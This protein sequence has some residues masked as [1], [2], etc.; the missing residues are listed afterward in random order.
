MRINFSRISRGSSS[1]FCSW[2]CKRSSTDL[3]GLS[4]LRFA[5]LASLSLGLVWSGRMPAV[6]S[7]MPMSGRVAVEI[8]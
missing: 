1:R 8:W 5:L 3:E 7:V 2:A 4:D 6:E